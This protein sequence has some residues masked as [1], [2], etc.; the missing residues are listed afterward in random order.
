MDIYSLTTCFLVVPM[1]KILWCKMFESNLWDC[2]F[3][4]Q[5]YLMLEFTYEFHL[6]GMIERISEDGNKSDYENLFGFY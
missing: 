1:F 3:V 4:Y 5:C 2:C 6:N